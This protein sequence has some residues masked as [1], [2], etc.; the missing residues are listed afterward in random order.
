MHRFLR[1]IC[2]CLGLMPVW[3]SAAQ[4]QP[5]AQAPVTAA[6]CVSTVDALKAMLDDPAFP[7]QWD[8]TTM[9]DG[10]PLRVAISEQHGV[11]SVAFVKTGKGLWADI[12]GEVC[13]GGQALEIRF[14]AKQIRFG[15]AASWVL[16]Y[17]LGDGGKFTL[18]RLSARQ[19]EVAT[20]GWSGLFA[21]ARLAATAPSEGAGKP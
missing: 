6:A 5:A 13:Q 11:M 21:P 17:V 1:L 3:P 10:L 2:V 9:D 16:R 18:K 15:P 20:T 14:S 19:L 8:E 4:T 12:T 7:L